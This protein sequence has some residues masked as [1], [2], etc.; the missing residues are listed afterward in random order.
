VNINEKD[1]SDVHEIH[2]AEPEE[3]DSD[4]EEEND[5]DEVKDFETGQIMK[6]F[7]Q[8]F[9]CHKKFSIDFGRWCLNR[10]LEF[11]SVFLKN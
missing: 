2:L 6:V 11:L 3:Y 10:D 7:M 5:E 1:V 9:M 4:D 8:D